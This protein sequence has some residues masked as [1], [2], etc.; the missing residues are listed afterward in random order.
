MKLIKFKAWDRANKKFIVDY[1]KILPAHYE[2]SKY[3]DMGG[4][5]YNCVYVQTGEY[6]TDCELLLYTGIRDKTG[7]DIY[8]GDIVKIECCVGL[9]E[10]VYIVPEFQLK[11]ISDIKP[12][13]RIAGQY[14]KK[15]LKGSLSDIPFD[16]QRIEVIGN[17]YEHPHLLETKS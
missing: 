5:D 9:Y 12:A 15:T 4:V 13:C 10:I 11:C 14:A 1:T 2:G 3:P 8:A 6:E 17:V 7:K 16:T